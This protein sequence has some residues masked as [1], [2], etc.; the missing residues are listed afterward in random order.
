MFHF[1]QMFPIATKQHISLH[2]H[3]IRSRSSFLN[4]KPFMG[5]YRL[6]TSASPKIPLDGCKSSADD[7]GVTICTIVDDAKSRNTATCNKADYCPVKGVRDKKFAYHHSDKMQE[8][9]RIRCR[10][11]YR[12]GLTKPNPPNVTRF[13]CQRKDETASTIEFLKGDRGMIDPSLTQESPSIRPEYIVNRSNKEESAVRFQPEV[14]VREIPSHAA[15][16]NRLKRTLWT[17]NEELERHMRRNCIEYWAENCDP[18]RVLEEDSFIKVKN[19]MIHPAHFIPE[20]SAFLQVWHR[21]A[22]RK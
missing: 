5:R 14:L 17:P 16:S 3:T 9:D 19:K 18:N 20:Y 22:T 15:L 11:L 21:S 8:D 4:K 2:Q 1:E 6:L 12:F 7:D 10:Y 13:S